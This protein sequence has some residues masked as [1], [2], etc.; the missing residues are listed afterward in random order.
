MALR[1]EPARRD[2]RA[3]GRHRLRHRP[4][5]AAPPME[6][7]QR[8]RPSRRDQGLSF[9]LPGHPRGEDRAL[10]RGRAA[11]PGRSRDE[12]GDG[13]TPL[14]GPQPARLRTHAH[15]ARPY[16]RPEAGSRST[17]PSARNVSR[18]RHADPRDERYPT[19]A[20]GRMG[21]METTPVTT[22]VAR[23]KGRCRTRR[24]TDLRDVTTTRSIALPSER[25]APR[26]PR[27]CFST[28][29][30]ASTL[31][32]VRPLVTEMDE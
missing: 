19:G 16:S 12:R 25:L 3:A 26:L 7:A 15:R 23:A 2:D 9:A 14:A 8:R 30:A 6:R 17:Q 22:M 4:L 1:H 31:P 13:R 20:P 32:F 28:K 5:P 18:A 24:P 11:L 10:G 27:R 21:V 29:A